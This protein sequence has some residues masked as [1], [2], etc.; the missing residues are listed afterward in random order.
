[1]SLSELCKKGSKLNRKKE[2]GK[3]QGKYVQNGT[4]KFSYTG[5][6]PFNVMFE[7]MEMLEPLL[8]FMQQNG[9]DH[10]DLKQRARGVKQ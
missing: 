7:F 8:D 3:L 2:A 9:I 10:I 6:Y 5:H 4:Y 1:M